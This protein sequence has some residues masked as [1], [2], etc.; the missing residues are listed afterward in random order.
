MEINI[1]GKTIIATDVSSVANM[2]QVSTKDIQIQKSVQSQ[3]AIKQT[4]IKNT[5]QHHALYGASIESIADKI[6]TQNKNLSFETKT[7]LVKSIWQKITQLFQ[8]DTVHADEY[9]PLIEYYEGIEQHPTDFALYYLSQIQNDD[10]SFGTSNIYET[11]VEVA[12][13][14]SRINRVD[15][16]QFDLAVQY[17]QQAE[18]KNNREKAMK[19]RMLYSLGFVAE[20]AQL[21]DEV[22]ADNLEQSVF[23][24]DKFYTQDIETNLEV[25]TAFAVAGDT[26]DPYFKLALI[27]VLESIPENWRV[28][29]YR[30]SSC[31]LS[32]NR[33][34][35]D[36]SIAI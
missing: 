15:N 20:H 28:R 31:E 2:K 17:I 14:L 18:P 12:L 16:S 35:I 4:I 29:V 22:V 1:D 19:A 3:D 32:F 36:A 34:N 33:K 7:S 8:I 5:D 25:L 11:T 9:V 13:A 30:W 27:Q 21:L 23:G 24:I 6:S 26:D 10:G